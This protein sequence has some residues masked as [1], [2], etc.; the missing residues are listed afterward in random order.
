VAALVAI[1]KPEIL[2]GVVFHAPAI[3]PSAGLVLVC[4]SV[5]FNNNCHY[6]DVS[7][8]EVWLVLLPSS[9]L[10]YQYGKLIPTTCQESQKR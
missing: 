3:L 10:N 2:D 6:D 9:L 4:T 7:S 8:S 5:S 1:Q